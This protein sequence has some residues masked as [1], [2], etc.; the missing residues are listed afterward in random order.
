MTRAV[1]RIVERLDGHG[2]IILP[3]DIEELFRAGFR[4]GP[5]GLR[6]YKTFG[7]YFRSPVSWFPLEPGKILVSIGLNP[8]RTADCGRGVNVATRFWIERAIETLKQDYGEVATTYYMY[9]P[10]NSD[11][12]LWLGLI[13]WEWFGNVVVPY[14]C[15]G[16]IRC[17]KMELV[18]KLQW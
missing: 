14:H 6:V 12:E 15:D 8:Y 5:D 17:R 13:R 7:L 9:L 1:R 16:K 3:G 11:P 10:A 4:F 2:C 18:K